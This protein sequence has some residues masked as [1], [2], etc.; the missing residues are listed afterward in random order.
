MIERA[1]VHVAGPP[2]GGKTMFLERLLESNRAKL[3]MVA[4]GVRDESLDALEESSERSDAELQ[5]YRDAG[6]RHAARLSFPGTARDSEA[7]FSSAFMSEYSEGVL[8]EGDSPLAFRPQLSVFVTP[9]IPEG[10]TLLERVS[11]DRAAA[12]Q[13]QLAYLRQLLDAPGAL[14]QWLDRMIAAEFHGLLPASGTRSANARSMM[15]EQL[16][17]LEAQKPPSPV[18]RWALADGFHGIERAGVVVINAC[19]A[20][21]RMRGEA[22]LPE[23]VRMRKDRRVFDDVIGLRGNRLPITAGVA[24]LADPKDKGLKRLVTRVKRAFATQK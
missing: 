2:S 20:D 6:A 13:R 3:L 22:M 10:A 4:R 12:H 8:I 21:E 5:R 18:E 11:E 19:S 9:P 14:E 16:A 1:F 15:R 7:F 17:Q 23:L 24:N